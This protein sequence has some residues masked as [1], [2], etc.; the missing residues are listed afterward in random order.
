VANAKSISLA[1]GL[2]FFFG[3]TLAG[4]GLLGGAARATVITSL[5]GGTPEPMPALT[6]PSYHGDGPETFGTGITW[7]SSN[8]TGAVFGYT[9]YY[10]FA[11]GNWTG[12]P[13][14]GTDDGTSSM[15]FT[16][17]TPVAA[18]LTELDWAAGYSNGLNIY[19]DAYN[20]K[21]TLIDS[22]ELANGSANLVSPGYYGFQEA[23]NDIASITLTGG[24]IGSRNISVSLAATPLPP[25]WLM[26]LSGFVGLGFFAY[27]GKRKN[28][29][30]AF[31]AA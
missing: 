14:A 25:T 18:F 6:D 30:A 8:P 17:A 19:I 9:S 16:L 27:R 5:P 3:P 22:L 4:T 1:L 23:S 11:V 26:L 13:M 29:A 21:G 24:D 10:G 2:F 12:T 31:A 28:A 7:T 15:T 20:T